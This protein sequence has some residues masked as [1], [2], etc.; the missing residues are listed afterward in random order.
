MPRGLPHQHE[1]STSKLTLPWV[2][3]RPRKLAWTQSDHS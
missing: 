3:M 1:G 2:W